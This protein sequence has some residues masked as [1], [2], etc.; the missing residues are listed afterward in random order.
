MTEHFGCQRKDE[1][2]T[3]LLLSSCG[4]SGGEGEGE[5]E[6]GRHQEKST[7]SDKLG[8]KGCR[9]HDGWNRLRRR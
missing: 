4:Q 3:L 9:G 7:L 5:D 2:L 1:S 8:C 6:G